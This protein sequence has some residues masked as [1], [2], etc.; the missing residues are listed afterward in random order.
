LIVAAVLGALIA[1]HLPAVA[2][3]QDKAGGSKRPAVLFF[4]GGV[5]FLTDAS[6]LAELKP[7]LRSGDLVMVLTAADCRTQ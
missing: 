3:A 1:G 2:T 5:L 6:A 4:T 7:L